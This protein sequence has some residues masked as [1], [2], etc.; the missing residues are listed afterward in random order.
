MYLGTYHPM[1][2][3]HM[4]TFLRSTS[5]LTMLFEFNL[6]RFRISNT[7]TVPLAAKRHQSFPQPSFASAINNPSSEGHAINQSEKGRRRGKVCSSALSHREISRTSYRILPSPL[8]TK[9]QPAKTQEITNFKAASKRCLCLQSL[10]SFA[11][12]SLL[13]SSKYA[14]PGK[15]IADQ[16]VGTISHSSIDVLLPFQQI[17][18]SPTFYHCK[19]MAKSKSKCKY[20]CDFQQGPII[21]WPD[22]N[23]GP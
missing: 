23:K 13:G 11:L 4:P 20:K 6:I 12:S 5:R 21:Y 15:Y 17:K 1:H 8:T 10:D 2:H 18:N 19:F 7:H 9:F 14:S 3:S 16:T 22:K